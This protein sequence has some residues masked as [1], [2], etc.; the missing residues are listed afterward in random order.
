MFLV[1]HEVN[2]PPGSR[3]DVRCIAK[4]YATEA[5]AVA[6]ARQTATDFKVRAWVY[7]VDDPPL[8]EG[9]ITDPD[10]DGTA[11]LDLPPSAA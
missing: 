9:L 10:A 4:T 7:Q 1:I 8:L 5:D 2:G 11:Y 3:R 6:R